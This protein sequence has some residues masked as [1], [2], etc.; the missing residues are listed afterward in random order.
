MLDA[1]AHVDAVV[2]QL[3][4][5]APLVTPE[6]TGNLQA[7]LAKASIG[8]SFVLMGG[9]CAEALPNTISRAHA[10]VDRQLDSSSSSSSSSSSAAADS[11]DAVRE[12]VRV[13]LQMSVLLALGGSVPVIKIG[14]MAGQYAKPRSEAQETRE[15]VT[16]P[17]YR[18]DSINAQEFSHAARRHDPQRMLHAYEHAAQ[19]LGVIGECTREFAD[20]PR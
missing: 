2:S 12:T 3:S 1:Q 8:Q 9:D 5:C 19:T 20:L 6:E 14:R 7:Q 11:Y 16:L 13:I 17:A 18:G 4:H 15:G 10:H